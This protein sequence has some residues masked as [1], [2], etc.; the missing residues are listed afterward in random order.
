[1][2]IGIL[3]V[4][5]GQF[6]HSLMQNAADV[7]NRELTQVAALGLSPQD[8]P[9]D[10]MPEAQRLLE[11]L[12]AAGLATTITSEPLVNAEAAIGTFGTFEEDFRK[13]ARAWDHLWATCDMELPKQDRAQLI[14]RLHISHVLQTCSPITVDLDALRDVGLDEREP[15]DAIELR[16]VVTAAGHEVV[17][18]DDLVGACEQR[19]T[20]VRAEEAGSSGH[21]DPHQ[22]RPTP[23]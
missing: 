1:M 8:D 4:T 9:R 11:P 18:T 22:R 7:L 20:Q 17:D 14:V 2:T 6:G 13:H 10:L 3:L 23:S 19:V 16:H 21:D 15:V 5:H 12:A